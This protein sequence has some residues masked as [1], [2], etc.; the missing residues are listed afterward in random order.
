VRGLSWPPYPLLIGGA[1]HDDVVHPR[2]PRRPRSRRRRLISVGIGLAVVAGT[3]VYVLPRIADYGDVWGVVEDLSPNGIGALVLATLLNLATF[4][5]PWMVALPRLGFRRAFVLTQA[6][7]ASTYVAPGG[8]AVGVAFA[9]AILRSWGFGARAVGLAAAVTGIWNQFALLGFPAVALAL[10]TIQEE[11]NALLE[12]VGLIGLAVF[13]VA[14]SAFA[15]GLSTPKLAR[16]VGDSAARLVN[17]ARRLFGRGPGGWTGE[18]FVRFRSDAVGLLGRRWHVLTLATLAGQLTVFVL[19]LVSLRVLGVS[20][21]EVSAVEAFAAWSLVRLLGSL[22]VTP[23]GIG[24]VEVG[25]TTALVGFGGDNPEVVAAV[26]V[27]RFLTIVPTLALGMIGAA[28][29]RQLRAP[30]PGSDPR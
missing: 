7:T 10:L 6:S 12:T 4:A 18:S 14:A 2:E 28:A 16:F 25:L 13:V 23:G 26:L 29:F 15:F 1:L 27:Y 30:Q 24:I 21:S 20:G 5:P 9:F 17:R 19:F 11:Q 22:P 3:F 8:A